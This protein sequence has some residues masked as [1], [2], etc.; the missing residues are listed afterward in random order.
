LLKNKPGTKYVCVA[1]GL[2]SLDIISQAVP[3]FAYYMA[4]YKDLLPR[5]ELQATRGYI[6]KTFK[7]VCKDV[8]IQAVSYDKRFFWTI[9]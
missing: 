8:G 1:F 3:T 5:G 9:I 4:N 2:D 6:I 7:Q